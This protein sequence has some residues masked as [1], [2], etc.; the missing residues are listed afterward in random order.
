MS[1]EKESS[2]SKEKES[3]VSKEPDWQQERPTGEELQLVHSQCPDQA[4]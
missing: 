4:S 2:V 3:S 1:K